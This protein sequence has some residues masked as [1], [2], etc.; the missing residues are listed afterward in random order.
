MEFPFSI[1]VL[2]LL[3]MTTIKIDVRADETQKLLAELQRRTGNIQPAMEGIGQILVS[4]TQQRFVDQVDPDGLPWKELSAVTLS[5]RRKAGSG[6]KIL[7]DTGRLAASINYRVVGG[8]V[9]PGTNV[10]YAPTH[11]YG[12]KKGSYGRTRKG[13]PIPWGDIPARPFFGYNDQDQA[14]VLEL[15]QRYIDAS[16]PQSWWQRFLDLFRR[17]F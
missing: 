1:A 4:N 8:S 12:A 10:V 3:A 14:D 13:S 11:Q 9:E 7:R 17:L 16:R 5:R 15:L 2:D 6:A